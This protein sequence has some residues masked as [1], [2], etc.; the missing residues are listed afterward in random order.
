MKITVLQV[1]KRIG[2]CPSLV[3]GLVESRAI[4]HYRVGKG[5]GKILVDE[6][7]LEAFLASRRVDAETHAKAAGKQPPVPFRLKHIKVK[8]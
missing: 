8:R 1:A 6:T 5:R 7:D 2:V 3:Y 4:A